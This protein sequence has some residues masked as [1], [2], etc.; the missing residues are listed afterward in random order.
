MRVLRKF[1]LVFNAVKSHFQQVEK[2]A[3]LGG[4]QLWAL[5]LVRDQ[6]GLGVSELA[7]AMDV[8]QPTASNLVRSL[9][10]LD[11]VA[12]RR[13]EHDG[14]AVHLHLRPAG[15]RVLRKAP[16]PFAGVLP[17]ALSTLD[18]ATL[19]RLETDLAALIVLLGAD[20]RGARIPLGQR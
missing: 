8:R 5:S 13:D 14:R 19:R 16:G 2:V 4:A 9:V 1:R 7:R 15:G 18:A 11:L 10:D 20:Q 12:V 17:Q 3:G 6:S